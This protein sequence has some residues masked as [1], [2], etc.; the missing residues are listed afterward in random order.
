[1]EGRCGDDLSLLEGCALLPTAS[2]ITPARGQ[3]SS[4]RE[5]QVGNCGCVVLM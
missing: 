4:V 5:V 2:G 1:M 3:E